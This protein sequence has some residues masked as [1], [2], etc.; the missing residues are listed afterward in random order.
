[1]FALLL[2]IFHIFHNCSPLFTVFNHFHEFQHLSPF[3]NVSPFCTIP[4]TLS[5]LF[6]M[7]HN[8]STTSTKFH[9]VPQVSPCSPSFTKSRKVPPGYT[10]SARFHRV[11]HFPELQQILAVFN[12]VNEC[13]RMFAA[14]RRHSQL[15]NTFTVIGIVH[16]VHDASP[17]FVAF[18]A[19]V[20]YYQ[21]FATA[22]ANL[23]FLHRLILFKHSDIFELNHGWL[24]LFPADCWCLRYLRS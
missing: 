8:V 7:T 18:T 9:H 23:V 13:S 20:S 6:T 4:L 10:N 14:V 19:V 16:N 17:L 12:H 1:M 3:H 5:R 2:T 24:H 11:S 21:L 15:F 22:R